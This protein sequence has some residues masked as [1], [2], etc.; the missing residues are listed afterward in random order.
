MHFHSQLS[1]VY[2][3]VFTVYFGMKP[4]VVLHGYEAVKEALIDVGEEF[5]GRG[6]FRV[7]ER[8]TKIDGRCVFAHGQR[9]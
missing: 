7:L 3:P 1:E 5:S 2:S 9:W 8:T 6:S 4:M